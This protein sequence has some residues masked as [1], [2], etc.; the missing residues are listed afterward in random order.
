MNLPL[1]HCQQLQFLLLFTGVFSFRLAGC[2]WPTTQDFLF[3]LL[4][5]NFAVAGSPHKIFKILHCKQK[6]PL[7]SIFS[8]QLAKIT[9]IMIMIMTITMTKI[10][11]Q[12]N[13]KQQKELDA[14]LDALPMTNIHS[15]G[16][17][18]N[19]CLFQL[20]PFAIPCS[21]GRLFQWMLF[22]IPMGTCSNGR[23]F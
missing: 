16:S 23:L 9:L 12:Q 21:N 22:A 20:T 17:R 6:S 8:S 4:L 5:P 14:L 11:K 13:N 3:S 7:P 10:T 15:D 2:W 18:S 1:S 19:G